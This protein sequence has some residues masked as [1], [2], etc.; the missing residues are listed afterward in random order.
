MVA[1]KA[2]HGSGLS[3]DKRKNV[4][5]RTARKEHRDEFGDAIARIRNGLMQL[6]PQTKKAR[7]SLKKGGI[8]RIHVYVRK[9]PVLEH[10]QKKGE[11]D[12]VTIGDDGHVFVHDC[13]M[14]PGK[15]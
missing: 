1:R 9:R 12:V 4:D 14:Y 10:E 8:Q 3:A 15:M 13:R 7:P 6:V 2:W 11:F 5:K